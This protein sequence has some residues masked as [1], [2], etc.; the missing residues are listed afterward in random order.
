M[1]THSTLLIVCILATAATATQ[2]DQ[3]PNFVVVFADDLGYGD[4]GCFGS[5]DIRTPRLDAMAKQGM[6]YTSFYA[7]TALEELRSVTSSLEQLE[8]RLRLLVSATG[9]APRP[10]N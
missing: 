4:L 10:T 8:A 1:N 9:P 5:P 7:H 2:A 3:P 6:K